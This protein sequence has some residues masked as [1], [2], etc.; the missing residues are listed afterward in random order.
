M[1]IGKDDVHKDYVWNERPY[2]TLSFW[3]KFVEIHYENTP[4]LIYW[5]FH[6]QKRKIFW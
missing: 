5:K 3:W 4:I 6:L 1:I 2:Q